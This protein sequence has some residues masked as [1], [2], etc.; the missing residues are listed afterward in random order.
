[1][2]LSA[3][4]AATLLFPLSLQAAE[5]VLIDVYI[6][7]K[8]QEQVKLAGANAHYQFWIKNDLDTSL[9]MRLIAPEP[10]IVDIRETTAGREAP[11]GSGRVKL[12]GA[13]DSFSVADLKEGASFRHQ[14]TLVRP[15]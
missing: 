13:R 7:G 5:P 1:M 9:E 10:L 4:L 3:L 2:K 12:V 8:L 6:D 15:N 11:N 14:Y